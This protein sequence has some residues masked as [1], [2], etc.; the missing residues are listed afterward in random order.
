[1]KLSVDVISDV[2]YFGATSASDG[3]KGQSPLL[4]SG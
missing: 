2:I 3:W 4:A 1:M